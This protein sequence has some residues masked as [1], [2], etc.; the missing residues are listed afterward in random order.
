MNNR[1]RSELRIL[2]MQIREDAQVAAEE[3]DSFAR[4]AELSHAQI[5]VLDVFKTPEFNSEIMQGYDAL[6]VGGAS[7]ANVLKPQKYSFIASAK[8]LL[9]FCCEQ[10]IPVFA[11]CFGFQLAVLALGGEII[12]SSDEFE[13]G[14]IPIRLSLAAKND[15][16]LHDTPNNFLAVSVHK[17]KAI[18]LPDACELLAFTEQCLHI[19][20]VENKRFWAFQFHPEVDREILIERLTIYKEQYTDSTE[21]LDSILADAKETPES[22]ILMKKFVDRILLSG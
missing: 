7:D 13:M 22:N 11:S 9:L 1:S 4:H 18:E 15:P 17:Q 5:D 20:K 8:Q 19:I 3:L 12:D 10:D 6:W 21:H 2:L 16:L 14:C